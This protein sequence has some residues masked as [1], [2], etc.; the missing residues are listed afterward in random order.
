MLFPEAVW[1]ADHIPL[2]DIRCLK[3]ASLLEI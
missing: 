2:F 1:H 3:G